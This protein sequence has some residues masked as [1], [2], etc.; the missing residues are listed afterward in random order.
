ML[1]SGYLSIELEDWKGGKCSHWLGTFC[2][3]YKAGGGRNAVYFNRGRT[4]MNGK[5]S[6]QFIGHSPNAALVSTKFKSFDTQTF[7]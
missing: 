6:R 1:Y 5:Y 2:G 3:Q 7:L 4:Q